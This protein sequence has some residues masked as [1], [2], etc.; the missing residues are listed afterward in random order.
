[1]DGMVERT[2]RIPL[3]EVHGC[4]VAAAAHT[5]LLRCDLNRNPA[6]FAPPPS[7][8]PTG[9]QDFPTSICHPLPP[10]RCVAAEY[11]S[12]CC[13]R[14]QQGKIEGSAIDMV[15]QCFDRVTNEAL[16]GGA[17]PTL[18]HNR[19]MSHPPSIYVARVPL[20][21]DMRDPASPS[22]SSA[23]TTRATSRLRRDKIH[24]TAIA[25]VPG[26]AQSP[27]IPSRHRP[28]GPRGAT[29]LPRP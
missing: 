27:R 11:R 26:R 28:P 21:D 1:M 8:T 19:E 15:N 20:S 25:R 17:S 22:S 18:C 9:R 10:S 3:R 14:S 16:A 29:G 24:L 13:G 23:L 5:Q 12:A 7:P 4:G 2:R 6:L